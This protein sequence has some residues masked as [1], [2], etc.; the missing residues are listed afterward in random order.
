M[1]KLTFII[2]SA[3]LAVRSIYIG[4]L[5][6]VSAAPLAMHM[7]RIQRGVAYVRHCPY[8]TITSNHR[9]IGVNIIALKN[10]F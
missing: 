2:A 7:R 4:H 8:P 5:L 1:F 6:L 3:L 10:K 9:Q